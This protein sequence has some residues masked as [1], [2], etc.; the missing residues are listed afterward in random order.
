M[1]LCINV[2]AICT[3]VL[4]KMMPSMRTLKLDIAHVLTLAGENPVLYL[5]FNV[6]AICTCILN[7]SDGI[8]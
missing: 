6:L 1:Y 2:H 8:S 5:Y 3:C 7:K 4:N